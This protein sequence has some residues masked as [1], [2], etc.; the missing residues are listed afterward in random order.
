MSG[1]T[2]NAQKTD[3]SRVD[4]EYRADPGSG[5]VIHGAGDEVS[6]YLADPQPRLQSAF[7]E[8]MANSDGLRVGRS[9]V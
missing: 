3:S 6:I 7:S 9:V 8:C 5:E 4:A 1:T 2:E